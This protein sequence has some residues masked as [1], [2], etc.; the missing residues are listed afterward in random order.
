[1]KYNYISI[2]G[3]IGSGK[4]TLSRLLGEA[5][6]GDL[7]LENFDNNPFLALF[8][9]DASK[10][11][12][13]VEL[14]FLVDRFHQLKNVT[15]GNLFGK[16]IIADYY[17]FK[18]L[19]FAK[20]NLNE[21]EFQLFRTFFGLI[22]DNI[23]KPDLIIYLDSS[24]QRLQRN[25]KKRN[26]SYEQNISDDYL[27]DIH[28]QYDIFLKTTEIPVMRINTDEVDLLGDKSALDSLVE[29]LKK[30]TDDISG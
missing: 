4:T 2:E 11:G 22:E 9:E 5:L 21:Q 12:F 7:I 1:M 3:N 30:T 25:I 29:N 10:Y 28:E 8:Y 23:P 16:P 26:R 14:S 17:I 18:C 24:I 19:L 20:N 27:R 6:D 13:H 15:K